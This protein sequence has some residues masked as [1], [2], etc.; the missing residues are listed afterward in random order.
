MSQLQSQ[1][2]S[3][4]EVP[5]LASVPL[6]KFSHVTFPAARSCPAWIHPDYPDLKL[7]IQNCRVVDEYGNYGRQAVMKVLSKAKI[8]VSWHRWLTKLSI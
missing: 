1:F 6:V 5:P 2:G 3:Q 7:V 4:S 8:V